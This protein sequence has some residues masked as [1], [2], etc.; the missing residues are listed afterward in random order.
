MS[1]IT[2]LQS[3]NVEYHVFSLLLSFAV[4]DYVEDIFY[5]VQVCEETREY[6]CYQ[7]ILVNII[8]ISKEIV[9]MLWARVMH[10][11]NIYKFI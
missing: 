5:T 10:S 3:S 1:R 2:Y 9:F 11:I 8:N 6:I 7:N 4:L